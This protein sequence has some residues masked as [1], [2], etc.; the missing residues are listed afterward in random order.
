MEKVEAANARSPIFNYMLDEKLINEF[1]KINNDK[2]AI[3]FTKEFMVH[4]DD[5]IWFVDKRISKNN[6]NILY[7]SNVQFE[8]IIQTVY[9]NRSILYKLIVNHLGV[10]KYY[11]E[12]R[13]TIFLQYFDF[14]KVKK[15]LTLGN[16]IY[17]YIKKDTRRVYISRNNLDLVFPYKYSLK[18]G[19][20]V[21][22]FAFN[23]NPKV[24]DDLRK[25]LEPSAGLIIKKSGQEELSSVPTKGYFFSRR[26]GIEE[27]VKRLNKI[28]TDFCINKSYFLYDKSG[29]ID[30]TL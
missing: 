20:V 4:K 2:P 25:F 7:S 1:W 5:F 18:I 14:F 16:N 12:R 6:D 30:Q 17:L 19:A 3:D 26:K 28:G 21:R 10:S 13:D 23:I 9:G 11:H 24:N 22:G 27:A 29:F 8:A 15:N